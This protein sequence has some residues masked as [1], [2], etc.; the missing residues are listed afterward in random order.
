[1]TGYSYET[2]VTDEINRTQWQLKDEHRAWR[3]MEL[4]AI[5]LGLAKALEIYANYG[6]HSSE[7]SMRDET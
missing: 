4:K 3:A 2:L 5:T 6:F 7:T 1:M